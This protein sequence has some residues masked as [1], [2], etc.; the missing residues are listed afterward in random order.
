MRKSAPVRDFFV[1]T[2]D[3]IRSG[4]TT[5]IYFVRTLDILKKAGKDRTPVV[6]EATTGG[7]PNGWPWGIFCGLEEVVRLLRGKDVS[8]WAL[9]EGSLFP[10][11]SSGWCAKRAASRRRPRGSASSRTESRSS[12]S[13]CGVCIPASRR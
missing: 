8:L 10:P 7:L 6:A 12:L 5:D 9:P 11:R 1:A 2:Q 3:E 13:A 4:R